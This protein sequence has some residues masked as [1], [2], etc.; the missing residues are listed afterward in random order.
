MA[1]TPLDSSSTS[2]L[3]TTP[4]YFYTLYFYSRFIHVLR[5]S[6]DI[7]TLHPPNPAPNNHHPRILPQPTYIHPKHH[8]RKS[9]HR[10]RL[11][12][13]RRTTLPAPIRR[14]ERREQRES[15]VLRRR[16][17]GPVVSKRLLR[18][19]RPYVPP[20]PFPTNPARLTHVENTDAEALQLTYDPQIVTYRSLLEFFYRMHDPTTLNRQGPDTGTQY[21][22][23]IFAHT[24]EQA[25]IANDVTRKVGKQWYTDRPVTTQVVGPGAGWKWWDAEEY[26][27]LYLVRNPGGYECPAQY[28]FF[29]FPFSSLCMTG[30]ADCG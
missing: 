2:P 1:M 5:S 3:P 29:L 27:Q 4:L 16:D 26:H 6:K 20:S 19:Y 9:H 22:S 23:A 25:S 14:R 10:R 28:V 21:R 18:F 24:D 8:V 15:R 30:W 7:N 13:G 12:L 17:V 11:L